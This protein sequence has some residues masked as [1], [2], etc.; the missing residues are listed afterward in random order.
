M[1]SSFYKN[2]NF[3]GIIYMID[4]NEFDRFLETKSELH[5]IINEEV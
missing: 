5:R 2:I 3:D 4:I 1:W